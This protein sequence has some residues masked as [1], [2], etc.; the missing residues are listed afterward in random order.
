MTIHP[1]LVGA[2]LALGVGAATLAHAGDKPMPNESSKATTKK[3][4]F[5]KLPDGRSVDLYTLTNANGLVAKITNFGAIL[6]E[7][8]VPDRSGHNG[9]VV[10]GFDNLDAYVKGHPF[11]GSTVGR[12]A[13]RIAKGKFTLDGKQYTLVVNNGPNHL[14]GGTVGFDKVIWDATP[15]RRA[16]GP[17]VRFHYISK[18]GEEGYPGDL[19]VT[20]VYT[21]TNQNALR[22]E[23]TATTDKPTV[24]N[25]TN[26]SYFNLA[27]H[28]DIR[29]HQL[30]L[31][32]DQF[33]A[34]DDTL[35][36]TGQ[37]QPVKGT[38][39][40]F[41]T[42]HAIGD[43]IDEVGKDPSGYDHC[44][45]V[46]GGGKRLTLA[47][48]VVEPATGRAM[49]VYTTEP[50]VQF[51]T[52]NFL[53]G[54][55]TGIGGTVYQPRAALCLEAGKFPDTPNHPKFPSAELRPGQ[56]YRQRTEYRFATAPSGTSK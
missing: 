12:Y 45:V 29:G 16:E 43:H 54:S 32:C 6:T 35:I 15:T 28:G 4:A 39:M 14:H 48:R 47:A 27:G 8:H 11:F 55:L 13:N 49:D 5:G 31:N 18:D 25:L 23:Y 41:T 40:D 36:P 53:D 46:N 30:M 17:A 37:L 19:D 26:H 21:L 1:G 10:L 7:L 22:I 33:V 38:N 42:M 9:D 44:Y 56:T 34:V 20:V 52:A 3:S 50:G 51:Y 24:C 2:L